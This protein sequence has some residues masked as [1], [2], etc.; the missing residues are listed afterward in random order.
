MTTDY[1]SVFDVF[2]MQIKDW[3][4]D[5]LFD[6]S[7]TDFETY[8][9]GFMNLVIPEFEVFCDQDL[10]KDDTTKLF[11]ETLTQKNINRLASMMV[12]SWL[13]KEIQD[14]K[15][16]RLHVGDKDFRISSEA[17]NLRAKESYLIEKREEISQSLIEYSWYGFDTTN[18]EN[19]VF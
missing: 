3:R 4:L 9:T 5:T 15:Q 1:S 19:G 16:I 8:L 13:H 17:N 2:M 10:T 18:W 14:I 11:T 7:T 6:T 12:I